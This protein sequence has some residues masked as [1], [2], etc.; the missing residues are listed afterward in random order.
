MLKKHDKEIIEAIKS[1][2][3]DPNVFER[4]TTIRY[5]EL[6]HK[7]SGL[8]CVFSYD[9]EDFEGPFRFRFNSFKNKDYFNEGFDRELESLISY[10]FNVWLI[11]FIK[12]IVDNE[13]EPD[14]WL[15][16]EEER[17]STFSQINDLDTNDF[18]KK[19]KESIDSSLIKFQH[20]IEENFRLT[21]ELRSK[22]QEEL[23]YLSNATKR[24]NKRDWKAIAQKIIYDIGVSIV[25]NI[26]VEATKTLLRNEIPGLFWAIVR[27]S[28]NLGLKLIQ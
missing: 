2:G 15:T 19:E 26:A 22:I 12:P 10:K 6:H 24:L 20:L 21:E 28:F 9:R 5:L 7:S 25:S 11:D 23:N 18:S 1:V 17:N 14:P 27:E 8:S 3:I 16:S 4:V 13:N